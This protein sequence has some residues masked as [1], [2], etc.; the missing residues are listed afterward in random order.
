MQAREQAPCVVIPASSHVPDAARADVL[1]W[2]AR[3]RRVRPL[4]FLAVVCALAFTWRVAVLSFGNG[5]MAGVGA[6]VVLASVLE[7]FLPTHYRLTPN[8][9]HSRCGWQ[10]RSLPW[11]A[12]KTVTQGPHGLHVS[13]LSRKSPLWKVRGITLRF[14]ANGPEVVEAVRRFRTA[15]REVDA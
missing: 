12:V 3:P 9:I 14:E 13:P 2:S 15:A 1:A 11:T 5:L 7:G 4:H 10:F 6:F 8:G